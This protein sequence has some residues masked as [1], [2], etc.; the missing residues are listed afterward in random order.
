M[1]L[2]PKHIISSLQEAVDNLEEQIDS[3]LEQSRPSYSARGYTFVIPLKGYVDE[4]EQEELI[5]RYKDAGWS[6][7]SIEAIEGIPGNPDRTE[8]VLFGK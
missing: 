4:W 2:S 3:V 6:E 1:A 5:K 7:V 8:V